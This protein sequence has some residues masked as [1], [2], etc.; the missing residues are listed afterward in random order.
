MSANQKRPVAAP[1]EDAPADPETPMTAAPPRPLDRPAAAWAAPESPSNTLSGKALADRR[2]EIAE[3]VTDEELAE[4]DA[5]FERA[6]A[7]HGRRLLAIA[8]GI[9][10]NRFS[11][12]DVVQQAMMNLYKHRRRY[13]WHEPGP[14]MR[15]ATVNEALRLLRPPRMTMVQD[16]HPAPVKEKDA[17][18]AR[19]IENETV[20]RVRAA[21]EQLP[22]H[23]RSALVLCEYEQMSYQQISQTLDCSIPQVKT[24]LHRAR[25]RLATMLEDLATDGQK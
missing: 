12:E 18:D 17:P 25:R 22:D 2:K 8:R 10:G 4:I 11:P 6:V 19:L 15:R 16:D 20:R 5:L 24:W 9:V 3:G 7:D 13:D 14:L 21:I 1:P 23:F